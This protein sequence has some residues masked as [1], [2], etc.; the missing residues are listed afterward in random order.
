MNMPRLSGTPAERK[1]LAADQKE[2]E[3]IKRTWDA[4]NA[5]ADRTSAGL[6]PQYDGAAQSTVEVL[7]YE[8]REY[9]VDRLKKPYTRQRLAD[10]SVAQVREIIERLIKLR[11]LHPSITDELI[12]TLSEQVKWA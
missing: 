6:P 9:G 7:M 1:V 11:P 4:A 8:L 10:L 3:R 2:R 5:K 12:E